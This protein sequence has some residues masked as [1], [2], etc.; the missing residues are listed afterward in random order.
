[1]IYKKNRKK[2]LK[3]NFK[4]NFDFFLDFKIKN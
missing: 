3:E 1:M 2:I 4:K